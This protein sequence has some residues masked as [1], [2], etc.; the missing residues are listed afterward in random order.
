MKRIAYLESG[1]KITEVKMK[2]ISALLIAI[3]LA[4]TVHA[5]PVKADPW[6]T[7]TVP[8]APLP[9]YYLV[10][11]IAALPSTQHIPYLTGSD[12]QTPAHTYVKLYDV[13]TLTAGTLYTVTIQACSNAWGCSAASAPF[14]FTPQAPPAIPTGMGIVVLP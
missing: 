8:A 1:E 14:S 4:V 9:D 5:A 3:L 10:T 13:A 12:G 6:L 11:G 7:L 2:I